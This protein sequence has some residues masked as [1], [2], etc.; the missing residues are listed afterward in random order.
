MLSA[1]S[2]SHKEPAR[3]A[4]QWW[5]GS[6]GNIVVEQ[7]LTNISLNGTMF[8]AHI[9]LATASNNC[10]VPAADCAEI[11]GIAP[12]RI[13]PSSPIRA[14]SISG[15]ASAVALSLVLS[16]MVSLAVIFWGA[17]M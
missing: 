14:C 9:A 3:Y 1:A 4:D 6:L 12:A 7:L 8:W 11:V 15:S 5:M 2:S 17:G 13:I 10:L 16:L